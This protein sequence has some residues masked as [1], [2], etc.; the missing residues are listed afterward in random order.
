MTGKQER[1]IK[2]IMNDQESVKRHCRR[3]I[4]GQFCKYLLQM[5]THVINFNRL[6]KKERRTERYLC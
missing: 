2:R 1:I 4:E 3:D 5:R 6:R